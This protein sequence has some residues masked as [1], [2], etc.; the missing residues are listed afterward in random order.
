MLGKFLTHLPVVTDVADVFVVV[1]DV[2]D[3]MV[4][5]II[6]WPSVYMLS[7]LLVE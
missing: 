2:L 6:K 4:L 5:M 7:K 3:V 1:V